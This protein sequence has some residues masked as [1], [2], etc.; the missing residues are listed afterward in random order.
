MAVEH[1]SQDSEQALDIARVVVG[2]LGESGVVL[3]ASCQG[4]DVGNDISEEV[5]WHFGYQIDLNLLEEIQ[6]SS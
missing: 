5:R 3:L 1:V 2:R 6:N 4:E